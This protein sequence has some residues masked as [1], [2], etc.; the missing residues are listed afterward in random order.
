MNCSEV[1]LFNLSVRVE[2]KD[3][4]I[5]QL[6]QDMTVRLAEVTKLKDELE[7]QRKKN[8]VSTLSVFFFLYDLNTLLMN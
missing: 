5:F 3:K 8:N 2:V 7:Q 6:Q 1:Q 4:E